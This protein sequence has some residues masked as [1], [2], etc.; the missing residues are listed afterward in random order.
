MENIA[1][2]VR[3][4]IS[5]TFED[6]HSERDYL[7]NVIFP[8]LREFCHKKGLELVDVDLRWGITERE[9][10]EDKVLEICLEE[11]DKC[12]PF[13]IGLLG[14]RYGWT[15]DKYH[16]VDQ[17]RFSWLQKLGKGHSVTELE[18]FQGVLNDP[19]MRPRAFFYFRDPSFIGE[20]PEVK[21]PE[22]R[23]DNAE[24]ANK[25]KKLKET[26]VSAYHKF[27]LREHCLLY[28]SDA[29]DE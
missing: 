12:K 21:V 19:E 24:Q 18:I 10:S 29:A 8:R 16:V 17:H 4:F 6:M 20:V 25:L 23:D 1:R 3:I 26:L 22:M 15:P 27:G 14:E 9:A 13:F 2:T 7:V 28:T 5:S 11:I